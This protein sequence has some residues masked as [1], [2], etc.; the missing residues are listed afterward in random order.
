L[1]LVLLHPGA[2]SME[3]LRE[4]R[5]QNLDR[6]DMEELTRLAEMSRRPKLVRAAQNIREL[7]EMETYEYETLG[8]S[9][10]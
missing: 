1:D 8:I 6:M 10:Q 9:K 7:A 3:Y 5:L 4:L 2:D